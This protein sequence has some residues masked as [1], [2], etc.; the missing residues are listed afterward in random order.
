[1]SEPVADRACARRAK[2]VAAWRHVVSMP[3]RLYFFL[4][5][6][7]LMLA[8]FWWA[9]VLGARSL[10]LAAPAGALPA[11]WMHAWL[12]VFG[13]LVFIVFGFLMTALPRWADA[14]AVGARAH[15]GV[16][17]ALAA[18][19]AMTFAGTFSGIGVTAA[20]MTTTGLAWLA[21]WVALAVRARRAG[22]RAAAHVAG[23]LL[24]LGLGAALALYGGAALLTGDRAA[25]A[26]VPRLG[27]WV[28]LA[29]LV[30]VVTHRML[31]FFA[32][33]VLPEYAIYRPS[34][35]PPLALLLFFGHGLLLW[36]GAPAGFVVTDA[37]LAFI[38]AYLLVRW[39]PWRVRRNPLLWS[40]FVAYA[41]LPVALT[42]SVVQGLCAASGRYPVLAFAPLHAL[43]IGFVTSMVFAMVTRVSLGHSGRALRMDRLGVG[44]FLFLQAAAAMRVAAD[45]GIAPGAR[46]TWMRASIVCMLVALVPWALRCIRYYAQPRVDAPV[47][48]AAKR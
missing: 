2:P 35:G 1:M 39:Q 25:F 10:G 32:A 27:V 12:L 36:L 17:L 7:A 47:R 23:V 38:A 5:L 28:F 33:G 43:T 11:G 14:P 42:L 22:P 29:P 3:H 18:G 13:A 15:G 44:C 34:W 20:G 31:P 21:G 4:G 8:L 26:R 9:L 24:L 46:A 19:Y 30:F 41:W 6:F 16:A 45:V 48:P 40:L 37:A